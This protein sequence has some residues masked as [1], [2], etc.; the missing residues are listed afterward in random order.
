MSAKPAL[1]IAFPIA[2]DVIRDARKDFEVL[3]S[4]DSPLSSAELVKRANEKQV[5]AL[6]V[7]P[8]HKIHSELVQKLPASVKIIATCS[9]GYD[10]L[11][12]KAGQA[13]KIVM[14]NT[15]D[16]LSDATADAAMMLM[17]A[18]SRRARDYASIIDQGW[19][20]SLGQN[21]FLGLEVTGKTLGIIGMGRIGQAV[22]RRARGFNMKI[23]YSNRNRLPAE[24]EQGATYFPDFRA[25]L[26]H[27]QI[28]SLHAPATPETLN[29]IDAKA[30]ALL[31]AKAVLVNTARGSL[32]DEDALIQALQS[33]RLFAAGLDVFKNEP[34]ID[35]RFLK[36]K[37]VFLT[38][39]T[40][41]ATLETRNAMGFRA[42]ENIRLVVAGDLP[43]D[44]LIA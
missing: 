2:E 36:L 39:H 24:L 17:L 19:G 29:L 41:S 23:L 37:N 43:R 16:V 13:R 35:P 10:H 5:T 3:D 21:Q 33:G 8:F 28:L 25:M 20:Y 40:A 31:P 34:Q 26:P 1:L 27:C 12:I 4:G 44:L 38:P 14:T 30:L 32:V 9:V 6:L 15:P 7:S 18:A 42:L 22:A 11:D